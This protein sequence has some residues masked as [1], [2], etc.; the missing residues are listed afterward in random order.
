MK[1]QEIS[2]GD[3]AF[4]R[5]YLWE[6]APQLVTESRPAVLVLPGGAYVNCSETEGEPV[7]LAYAKE[8]FQTFVLRYSGCCGFDPPFSQ[9]Q[10]AL[11]IIREHAEEWHLRKE[12][13]AAVGFSAGGHLACALGCMGE[14]GPDAMVLGYPAVYNKVFTAMGMEIPDLSTR[15]SSDCPP[16]FLVACRD[17]PTV[18]VA[19]TICLAEA[20]DRLHIPF[21]CHIYEEGGHGFSLAS[22][23]CGVAEQQF[24]AGWFAMS[25]RWLKRHVG[26]VVLCKPRV[27]K[28]GRSSALSRS[29][30]S[31]LE[32]EAV[33][34]ALYDFSPLF[35]APYLPKL[36]KD[37]SLAQIAFILG[38][39]EEKLDKLS[40][41]LDAA[42]ARSSRSR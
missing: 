41:V 3:G 27:G 9:A 38:L 23:A 4:L 29:F 20:F 18:P 2:L 11:K 13:V 30:G 28:E 8:G 12:S 32:E 19:N 24:L 39:S 1:C 36:A 37:A 26:D 25:V 34:K 7:A 6:E 21:E 33:R 35:A 40:D 17:D 15:I 14:E 10:L 22:S 31:L 5:T 42:L 16:A